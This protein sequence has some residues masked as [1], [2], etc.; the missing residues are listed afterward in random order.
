MPLVRAGAWCLV[1]D[2]LVTV[3]HGSVTFTPL[4]VNR[5]S[6]VA[7]HVGAVRREVARRLLWS[8]DRSPEA[9]RAR[10]TAYQA[11]LDR[12]PLGLE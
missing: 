7:R 3:R 8:L 6:D 11:C 10:L 1:T 5:F 4:G 9:V 12:A 2:K